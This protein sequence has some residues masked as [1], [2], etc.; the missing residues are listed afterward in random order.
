MQR[1]LSVVVTDARGRVV[2]APGLAR[3][4]ERAAPRAARG[5]ATVA[6]VSDAAM[7]RLNRRYRG[8]DRS[9]DVLSFGPGVRVPG[10]RGGH[11]PFR[12]LGDIVIA[13]ETARRQSRSLGHSLG[14]ELRVLAL[15]GLLHLLG[16]DH[17]TD[18][19][20]MQ[21]LEARLRRRTGLPAG[22]I[23]RAHGR[24]HR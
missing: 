12:W 19:G 10:R 4:L 13:I 6:L 24:A 21:R 15:H 9:T 23:A 3:W 17:H 8:V 14:V 5:E 1:R 11:G 7:R 20:E 18:Q 16:Y 2:A 22:V